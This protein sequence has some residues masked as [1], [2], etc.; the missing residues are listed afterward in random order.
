METVAEVLAT[1]FV[2][3]GH[4]VS[5]VTV[6]PL[7]LGMLEKACPFTI[8]R[9]PGFT[10]YFKLL[11]QADVVLHNCVSLKQ[12]LPDWLYRH[13]VFV[14]HH[15]WYRHQSG[16]Q[17]MA[18]KLKRLM[19][20]FVNNVFISKAIKKAL[21]LPG[22]VIPNPYN[23]H[24]FKNT[25]QHSRP[26]DL[27]FLGRL[28][29]DK[30]VQVLLEALQLAKDKQPD[31][32]PQ[33]T[34]IGEGPER[35]SLEHFA[36]AHLPGQVHFAGKLSGQPLAALLNTHRIMVVPSLWEEPFG[37]VALE[38]LACGC[39]VIGSEQGGLKDAI[40]PCGWTFPNGDAQALADLLI[41]VWTDRRDWP[42]KYAA[43]PEH[44]FRH[45][46]AQVVASYI[47]YFNERV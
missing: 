45:Q 47:N 4:E 13:K 42:E 39:L 17:D 24:V 32:T 2:A 34:I 46:P 28:V 18:S 11:Q 23:N 40:G 6:T 14:I 20:R 15:T 25:S 26:K 12:V 43:V 41:T 9:N 33:L 38:G 44:L 5:L 22:K 37:V 27:V 16:Q 19:S 31:F 8:Y 36:T 21:Q 29:S 3:A 30:G 1:G 35:Q 7:P 10:A